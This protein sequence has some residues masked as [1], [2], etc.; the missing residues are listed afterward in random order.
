[1]KPSDWWDQKMFIM[2]H[3]F[4]FFKIYTHCVRS[5]SNTHII[6]RLLISS[7][8][9]SLQPPHSVTQQLLMACIQQQPVSAALY[10]ALI[11]VQLLI[12]YGG[13]LKKEREKGEEWGIVVLSAST[14]TPS[15]TWRFRLTHLA[16]NPPG[17]YIRGGWN[18]RARDEGRVAI[19]E[20]ADNTSLWYRG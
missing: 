4:F 9:V 5:F 8:T 20:Q 13:A 19:K 14:I 12:L 10:T 1:M 7:V 11:Q 17:K 3:V 6:Y 2:L 15:E 16:F 18:V